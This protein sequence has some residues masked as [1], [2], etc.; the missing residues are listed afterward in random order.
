MQARGSAAWRGFRGPESRDRLEQTLAVPQRHADLFEVG[1]DQVAQDARVDL[2]L[3]E[4]GF[5]LSEVDRVRHWATLIVVPAH[6]STLMMVP[7]RLRVQAGSVGCPLWVDSTR[8][9]AAREWLLFAQTRR[10]YPSGVDVQRKLRSTLHGRGIGIGDEG[11][12]VDDR[13][14]ID[15]DGRVITA[16]AKSGIGDVESY[17]AGRP[18]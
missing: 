13:S 4:H 12:I 15:F 18:Q 6:G 16:K 3:A 14:L 10:R 1:F 11:P 5:V 9:H 2:M 7:G 17:L 8:S